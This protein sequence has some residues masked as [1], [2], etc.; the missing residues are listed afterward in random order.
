M[1]LWNIFCVLFLLDSLSIPYG[2]YLCIFCCGQGGWHLYP[3]IHWRLAVVVVTWFWMHTSP[4]W[5]SMPRRQSTLATC[6]TCRWLRNT[7]L[8]VSEVFRS[9]L[10]FC[11]CDLCCVPVS[12]GAISPYL[13][14]GI[15]MICGTNIHHLNRHC[16]REGMSVCTG[17]HIYTVSKSVVS[18]TLT[19]VHWF[20][21]FFHC[22]QRNEF[23]AK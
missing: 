22:W 9:V 1:L 6:K 13:S 8:V 11:L 14:G 21:Q 23:F 4:G 10:S 3:V 2:V 5:C 20:W 17:N 18:K 12:Y 7:L 19:T 16:W 15:W